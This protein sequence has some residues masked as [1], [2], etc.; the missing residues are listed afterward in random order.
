MPACQRPAIR[1]Q[2]HIGGPTGSRPAS[3]WGHLS[4]RS[5]YILEDTLSP[6]SSHVDASS[7]KAFGQNRNMQ[8]SPGVWSGAGQP[9]SQVL[10]PLRLAEVLVRLCP[11]TAKRCPQKVSSGQNG[12]TVRRRLP[13]PRALDVQTGFWDTF[14]LASEMAV[15]A[16]FATVFF[17]I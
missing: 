2:C 5:S 3:P 16:V 15:P 12:A 10:S 7:T 11:D 14:E 8:S 6:L 9:H 4:A 17:P 1:R 13:A